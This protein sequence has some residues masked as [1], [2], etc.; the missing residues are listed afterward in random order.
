MDGARDRS[1]SALA[2]LTPPKLSS[3]KSHSIS[4]VELASITMEHTAAL[5]RIEVCGELH[6]QEL[7]LAH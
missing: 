6:I 2:A 5:E 7:H 1:R 4:S 3:I